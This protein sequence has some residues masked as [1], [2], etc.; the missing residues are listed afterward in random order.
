M[1][2]SAQT[3]VTP[4]RAT[5]FFL[6]RAGFFDSPVMEGL[7]SECFTFAYSEGSYARWESEATKQY[8]DN[9]FPSDCGEDCELK[10]TAGV[11]DVWLTIGDYHWLGA[12]RDCLAQRERTAVHNSAEGAKTLLFL[13]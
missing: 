9:N 6:G 1:T 4:M 2:R 5:S 11:C 3:I 8:L 7:P 12:S 10:W 13:N